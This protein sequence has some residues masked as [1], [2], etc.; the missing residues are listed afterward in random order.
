MSKKSVIGI[1]LA[2]III[3][4][5]I[6]FLSHRANSPLSSDQ[7][8]KTIY[9]ADKKL[10]IEVADTLDKQTLGLSYRKSMPEDKGMLFIFPQLGTY[11]FWMKDMNFSLDLIW[12]DENG[13]IVSIDK[14]I[15]PKTYPKI[16]NP[17]SPV[18]YVLE[19]NAGWSDK[20][21]IKVGDS[22]KF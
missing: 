14:N 8:Q 11:G 2:V 22:I 16:F 9:V 10:S 18:K 20:N 5:A 21:G 13:K 7:A 6:Y 12:L 1:L 19:V 17:S 3:L 15:S 4:G